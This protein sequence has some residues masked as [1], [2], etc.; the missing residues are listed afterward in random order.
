[1]IVFQK[2]L[3]VPFC[4]YPQNFG[5]YKYVN[6]TEAQWGLTAFM[7]REFF[8]PYPDDVPLLRMDIKMETKERL[9]VKVICNKS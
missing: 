8:S 1:L 5:G 2:S 4:F 7:R 3:E 9:R 6:V